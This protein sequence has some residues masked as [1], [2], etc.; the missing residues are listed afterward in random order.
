MLNSGLDSNSKCV[1][2]DFGCGS[3]EFIRSISKLFKH[4]KIIGIDNTE[5]LTLIQ[6][7]SPSDSTTFLT[8]NVQNIPFKSN[9][10]DCIVSLDVLEHV[11]DPINALQEIKRVL[12]ADGF[13]IVSVP[14]EMILL[15]IIREFF[16]WLKIS[17]R[18]PAHYAHYH[19]TIKSFKEFYA[20]LGSFFVITKKLYSPLNLLGT[21]NYGCIF[22]CKKQEQNIR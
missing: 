14:L 6:K 15:R 7:L 22:V 12:K 1:I 2:G 5:S 16:I 4:S 3:G 13:L 11:D 19:G 9:S 20:L 8:C 21:L 18:M 17:E 10:F